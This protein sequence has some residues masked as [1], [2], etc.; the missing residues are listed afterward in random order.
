[1]R[2]KLSARDTNK[3][4]T[5]RMSTMI[6]FCLLTYTKDKEVEEGVG[7]HSKPCHHK[8]FSLA[9]HVASNFEVPINPNDERG[10]SKNGSTDEQNNLGHN[11]NWFLCSFTS[12]E[13][14]SF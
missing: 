5:N 3:P 4:I 10:E 13:T 8:N 12:G 1:M 14:L 11:R 7:K 9:E 2:T 6:V